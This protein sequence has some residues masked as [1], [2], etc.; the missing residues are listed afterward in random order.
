MLLTKDHPAGIEPGGLDICGRAVTRGSGLAVFFGVGSGALL[1]ATF[2]LARL[3]AAGVFFLFEVN[4]VMVFVD[5]LIFQVIERLVGQ[6]AEFAL[7]FSAPFPV[8][9]H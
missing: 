7:E 6:D 2:F 4:F 8:F 5:D 3:T 1:G 9:A